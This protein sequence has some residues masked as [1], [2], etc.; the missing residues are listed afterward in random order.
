MKSDGQPE[1][2]VKFSALL[3]QHWRKYQQSETSKQLLDGKNYCLIIVKWATHDS[4]QKLCKY[5]SLTLSIQA[6]GMHS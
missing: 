1:K 5:Q 4:S 2:S 6:L 3:K